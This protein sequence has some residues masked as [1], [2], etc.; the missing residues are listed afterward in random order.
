M[1]VSFQTNA[2]PVPGYRL[3]DRLGS[4]GFG[5]VWK[6]E[7]PGGI[8]KA[9]K[10][11][12][13][14]LRHK[15]N[16]AYRF[17]EQ[18]LKAMKRVKTVR[19]PYLLAL[20]RY[21]IV[22]GRLCIVMEL[23][24]CNLWDRFRECRAQN[25]PGIPRPEL[26]QYLFESAE[27]L[28]LMN[29][30]HQLQHL[31]IKP[32]N[33]FL[34][35]NH[36]KV[37]DFGQV[38][39]LELHVAQ[40]TGGI[41]PVYAA[42]E[43]FDGL[44]SRYCDQYS[45]ACVYQE[46]LTGIRPFDGT[47]MTQLMMQHLQHAPNLEPSPPADRPALARA[48][49]KK[50]E[51]RFRTVMDMAVAIRD[52]MAK[53]TAVRIE[54]PWAGGSQPSEPM[55]SLSL[56]SPPVPPPGNTGY[57]DASYQTGSS[58]FQ[59]P[60]SQA[61]DGTVDNAISFTPMPSRP[62]VREIAGDGILRPTLV[63]GL[64]NMGV[65]ATKR[66]RKLL[67]QAYGECDNVPMMRTLAIDTDAQNLTD[68][69][70]TSTSEL[71]EL[72]EDATLPIPLN[73]AAYYLRPRNNGRALFEG[74]L[75]SSVLYRMPRVP[76]TTGLRCLGRLAFYDHFRTIMQR[77][78]GEL[79]VATNNAALAIT[80][81]TTHQEARTNL[82]RV[83]VV[84]GLG[85]GTGS[86]IVFDFAYALRQMMRI[87]GYA[88][89]DVV[90]VLLAPPNDGNVSAQAK[91][92]TFAAITELNH[93]SQAD[94]KFQAVFDEAQGYVDDNQMPFS[95]TVILRGPEYAAPTSAVVP[96]TQTQLPVRRR[97]T[98]SSTGAQAGT[99]NRI[100]PL[101]SNIGD[102]A[103]T[104]EEVAQF[105][106]LE[107]FST[108]GKLADNKRKE[109]APPTTPMFST[110]GLQRLHWPR[111]EVVKRAARVIAPVL[112][113][114]WID[115]D[116]TQIRKVVP[117]WAAEQWQRYK[118]EADLLVATLKNAVDEAVG[119][120]L[121]VQVVQLRESL[122][123]N[124]WL[125]RLPDASVVSTR[126]GELTK[127]F[128]PPRQGDEPTDL[129]R[130]LEHQSKAIKK[131]IVTDWMAMIPALLDTSSFRLAGT[132]EVVRQLLVS[133][134]RNQQAVQRDIANKEKAAATAFDRLTNYGF[135]VKG[136]KKLNANEF[137]EALNDYPR[138]WYDAL[139]SREAVGIY[140]HLHDVMLNRLH[141][142]SA[143][144]QRIQ[145]HHKIL[146]GEADQKLPD[147][148]NGTMVPAGCT[149]LEDAAQRY[150][151][152]LND[153]DL[154]ALEN[155]FQDALTRQMGGVF[156]SC[157][158]TAEGPTAILRILKQT[159]REYLDQRLGE[160][161]FFAMM[162]QHHGSSANVGQVVA[163][164]I[165]EAQPT[166]LGNGPWSRNEVC[167]YLAPPGQSGLRITQQATG[168]L[169]PVAM[170]ADLSDEVVIYREHPQVP[171]SALD[172]LGPTW[173]AAYKA[174]PEQSQVTPHSRADITRWVQVD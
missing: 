44:V 66:V 114:H 17:A 38:K 22:D 103:K 10:V 24:D 8:F 9:M 91:A 28:D 164:S 6:C 119:Y 123:P 174:A 3:I 76:E 37:A 162:K 84:A 92:N 130:A 85:G 100:V 57:A 19:H 56:N 13:G 5:E 33:L 54:Q 20:D 171:I 101:V 146:V 122:S 65:L 59:H 62:A 152:V 77:V 41:T 145:D 141:E 140:S 87:N 148:P 97:N 58:V 172:Q 127:M 49:S 105:F 52:G 61:L 42:P 67:T 107:L 112:L 167:V 99:L 74:W 133:L 73:R 55:E 116:P 115:P 69:A 134:E 129:Q 147:E 53:P 95:R 149:S 50:P 166:L 45:L 80:K 43:T 168:M 137:E 170:V 161:D 131:S 88:N 128:G 7:A 14:D 29:D 135:A 111:H 110:Y 160:V 154:N 142:L 26:M 113:G 126:L 60:S 98:G 25:L 82:P 106:R 63:I 71:A 153:D 32:Q 2:E 36:V 72:P 93:Y 138:Q 15:D 12:H 150:L 151:K 11:I 79:D 86:G 23:A 108:L 136:S 21:D 169:P 30:K 120:N 18:E 1:A 68:A 64:G 118:L 109:L 121:E 78:L 159:T 75:D 155:K 94:T 89:P 144:R 158:N 39:D 173:A 16:D 124:G 163:R 31:D 156:E 4:G 143:C 104:I 117:R 90:G 51:D 47:S 96:V 34:L 102:P 40:V 46:L 83:Y 165:E 157:L 35:Y 132:E 139:V 81:H 70:T 125:K 27:V 48:L